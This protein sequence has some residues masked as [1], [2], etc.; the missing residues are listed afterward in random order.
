MGAVISVE[1]IRPILEYSERLPLYDFLQEPQKH[2]IAFE[3][4]SHLQK[5]VNGAPN[6]QN[7]DTSTWLDFVVLGQITFCHHLQQEQKGWHFNQKCR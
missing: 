3:N 4:G 2:F 5:T 1:R 7:G 6:L